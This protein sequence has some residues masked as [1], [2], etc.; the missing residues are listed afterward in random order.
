MRITIITIVTLCAFLIGTPC[1][2]Q[3]TQKIEIAR[4]DGGQKSNDGQM[5][6]LTSGYASIWGRFDWSAFDTLSFDTDL[7]ADEPTELTV[8][9]RDA[10]TTDYWTRMNLSSIIPPGKSTFTLPL[11]QLYVGEKSRPGRNVILNQIT[12][13]TIS[14]GQP[15]GPVIISNVRLEQNPKPP[16]F[17]GLKAFDFG[18]KDSPVMDGFT[19]VTP[20]TTYSQQRGYGLRQAYVLRANDMLQPDPLYQD[21]LAIVSGG[22]AVDLPNGKYSVFVNLD[23]PGEFWGAT[24]VFT[25]RTILANGTPVAKD[26]INA[27][28]F[29]DWYFRFL[30]QDDLPTDNTFDKYQLNSYREKVFEVEVRNGQLFLEFRGEGWANCVSTVIIFPANNVRE[31]TEFLKYVVERRRFYFDNYFRRT[32]HRGTGDP[33]T[34]SAADTRQGYVVFQRNFMEDI[35]YNDT[36]RSGERISKL[37]GEAFAGEHEPVTFSLVPLRDLGNVAVKVS[38]LRGSSGTIPSSA[39]D[40]GYISYRL[41]RV[42]MDGSIYT[43]KPRLIMPK[44]AVD[45]P[46]DITRTFLL[47]VNTPKNAAAGQYEGEITVTASGQ[48]FKLPLSF[49]VRKGTLDDVDIPVGPWGSTIDLPWR[50]DDASRATYEKLKRAGLEKLRE[51]GFNFAT[52]APNIQYS[53]FRNGQPVLDFSRADA[54]MKLLRELGFVAF[55][56][57][58]GGLSGLNKYYQDEAAMRTAGTNDYSAFVKAIYTAI[59]RHADAQNWIP[60][61]YNLAD[62]PIG[63]DMTRSRANAEAYRKA[64]PKGPPFFT[65]A[66]SY[67]G[68]DPNDPHLLL[69]RAFHIANWNIHSEESVRLLQRAG[70][71]WAFYNGGNRWTLGDYMFKCVREFNMKFRLSWHY[72]CA[73]GNPYYA[74]D[75]RE[76]DYAWINAAPGGNMILSVDF[77]RLREGVYD[78][79]RLQ[80]LERL[81]RE[82]NDAA[83]KSLI[84]AR[85]KSFKLGQRE[86]GALFPMSDWQEFRQKT[87]DA[88]ERLR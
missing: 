75:C 1:D 36:P 54:D 25:E 84:D 65:G 74:L 77:D 88:I 34:P 49:R 22:F 44:S 17:P 57:Y 42:A 19:P 31:G 6:R 32:L 12:Q 86:H 72:N 61:Y 67:G 10:Q 69:G 66:S 78:Y 58:G 81:A 63:D 71:D 20:E 40:V 64:F 47:T 29:Y 73:A 55:C 60:V 52:G 33:L 68:N 9:I 43:I 87:S 82:K 48:D 23:H 8:E 53:G 4:F 35:Y 7:N 46:K 18:P 83:A 2:A 24:Q 27:E 26:T 14:V 59:Q 5:L 76:D 37:S 30:E 3:T 85:M 21:N 51:Y 80:T 79:R 45:M 15:K 11:N 39:I 38:D 50:G 16:V 41:S 56:D 28:Q 70:A 13:F 62:E